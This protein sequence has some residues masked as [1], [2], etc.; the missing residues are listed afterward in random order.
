MTE[1]IRIA[2]T[3]AAGQIAYSLLF[4]LASGEVFGPD[5]PV[6]LKLLEIPQAMAPLEGVMMELNDCAYDTLV[7]VDAYDN[8]QEAF[9]GVNWA[10]M[11]GSRPRSAG[12]ERADLI[13]INGPIFVDQGKALDRAAENVR[14][15]VVG[16]PCNT[17]CMIAAHNSSVPKERFSAM[18]RLDQ[19]RA[20]R[21]L[22]KKSET[23]AKKVSNMVIW[24]NHSNNQVPDFYNARIGG[25][26]AAE[27]IGDDA[28]LKE[29]FIPTVQNRGAAVIKARGASSAASAANA[30]LDHCKSLITPTPEGDWFSAGVHCDGAYGVESGLISS[31][32]LRSKGDGN[33]EIV[34]GVTMEPLIA[35]KYQRVLEELRSERETV[36]DLLG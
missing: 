3:G 31:V 7:G 17:N 33:W 9:D 25:K 36:K 29:F 10:F 27:V 15:I 35:E 4:R 28:W 19:N 22:S 1:P 11:V 12:M 16:N 14:A 8:A 5:Q 26:P 34:E 21:L 6:Y 18:M 32:P 23:L 13:K 2:V 20:I 24:G 30:A